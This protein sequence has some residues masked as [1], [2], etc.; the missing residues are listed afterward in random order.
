MTG[1]YMLKKTNLINFFPTCFVILLLLIAAPSLAFSENLLSNPGFENWTGGE[2]DVWSIDGSYLTLE[3]SSDPIHSGDYAVK[4]TWTSDDTQQLIQAIPVSGN[5]DYDVTGWLYDNDPSGRARIYVRWNDSDGSYIDNSFPTSPSYTDDNT[6]WQEFNDVYTSPEDAAV[7]IIRIAVYDDDGWIGNANAYADDICFEGGSVTP[8]INKAYSISNEEIDVL[9]STNISSVDPVDYTLSGS[10]T[11]TFLQANI[12]ATNPKL[13]HLS[14]PS[15][16]IDGDLVIDEINDAANGTS[17]EFYAGITPIALTNT[18]YPAGHIENDILTT[19]EGIVSANDG[20]NNVWINDN[21]GAY[22]AVLIYD[23][24]FTDEVTVGD[25]ILLSGARDEYSSVTEIKNPTLL[26]TL[27]TGNEPYGPTIIEGSDIDSSLT[28]NSDPAEKY[29]GQLVMISDALVEVAPDTA[30]EEYYAIC[31]DDGGNTHFYVGDQVDY[32]FANLNF[33]QGA[34]ETLVG[35]IDWDYANEYYR[36]NPRN[37]Q[38]V[39]VDEFPNYQNEFYSLYNVPNPAENH[40]KISFYNRSSTPEKIKIY[41]LSGQLIKTLT[42][43]NIGANK[44]VA[45]WNCK[46]R[47]GNRVANGIYFYKV[48]NGFNVLSKKMLILK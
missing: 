16:G 19:F 29:E 5:T 11:I 24:N 2:P 13:V 40:T 48:K 17:Y 30:A 47:E 32:H 41:N 22:N 25:M 38:D 27:S 6:Q 12:D 35:V 45:N 4:L 8:T 33:V 34:T 10:S 18:N 23:Y 28:A 37:Q 36:L 1:V 46:D 43:E 15:Q 26:N 44:F 14:E 42:P 9:Y 3:Q 21:S 7:A 31:T 39:P 20:Y